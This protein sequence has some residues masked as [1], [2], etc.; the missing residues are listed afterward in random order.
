MDD[1]KIIDLFFERSEQAIEE[2]STKYESVCRAIA[3][4]IL[5]NSLDAEE[6]VN[7][8][9]LAVW[10]TI[11]PTVPLSLKGYV[12]GIVRKL[13]ISKYHTNSAQKRNSNYD[14]ALDELEACLASPVTVEDEIAVKELSRMLNNFLSTLDK[15]SR[16]I[17]VR[18]YWYSDSI[19]DIAKRQKI[20]RNNT[21]VRLTRIREKLKQYLK[22]EGYW[23]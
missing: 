15:D 23:I 20:S 5:S 1:S 4:N 17:F 19:A 22:K 13:S 3:T 11:P 6:C 8:T 9:F 16:V 2:L 10:N 7:D 21:S 18:R 14:I 12:C